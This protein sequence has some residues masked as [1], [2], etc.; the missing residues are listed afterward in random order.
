MNL[1]IP[2]SNFE[3]PRI[4]TLSLAYLDFERPETLQAKEPVEFSGKARDEVRLLVS[5][6]GGHTHSSFTQLADFL[7][8]GDVLVVNDSAT[9]PASLEAKSSSGPF[10][11][12]LSTRYG[13]TLWLAEPRTD[14]ATPEVKDLK[15]GQMIDV[16]GVKGQLLMPYSN[17][18]RLW[19]VQFE[20]P[21]ENLMKSYGKPIRYGYTRQ[22]IKLEHY[23]TYF[24][25][26]PGSAEMPSAA[27]PFSKRIVDE[28]IVRGI[29]IAPITLHTG[30]SS[31]EIETEDV[32]EHSLYPEPFEVSQETASLINQAKQEGRRIIAVG[33]T[34]IRALESA[35]NETSIVAQKGFTKRYVHPRS[36]FGVA[37]GLIT[38]LHDPKA[39]H[40]AMLYAV[41]GQDLI[42][43]AYAEAVKENYLWHE[44][45][46]SHLILP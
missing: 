35:W 27:R 4:K 22:D 38:G 33:T 17:I 21:V 7:N 40:L 9:L 30:V 20:K 13:D 11:L 16:F 37:R 1:Q 46:D 42:Q 3:I 29:D 19:F 36:Y 8:A 34:V 14:F 10:L 43:G 26:Q 31:L 39:S 15:A 45:G 32:L 23:Q 5:H 18:P 28:L 25:S 44:F 41:A 24:S 2:D 12:N 6:A